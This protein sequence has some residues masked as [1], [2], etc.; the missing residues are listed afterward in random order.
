MKIFFCCF[1]IFANIP[2]FSIIHVVNFY[3]SIFILVYLMAIIWYSTR[4]LLQLDTD[5]IN[6]PEFS[7]I[8]STTFQLIDIVSHVY[9]SA[10]NSRRKSTTNSQ[11]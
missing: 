11:C 9:K 4:W 10:N 2:D 1:K 5:H 6:F 3:L 8:M 7:L